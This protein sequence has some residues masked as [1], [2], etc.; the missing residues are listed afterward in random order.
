LAE[1]TDG[2]LDALVRAIAVVDGKA[3]PWIIRI[4]PPAALRSATPLR[5][6]AD[7]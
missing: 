7:G 4:V 6:E 1:D 2:V 3:Y 5:T